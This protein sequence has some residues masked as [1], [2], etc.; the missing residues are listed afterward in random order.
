MSHSCNPKQL[1]FLEFPNVKRDS[2]FLWFLV[3]LWQYVKS[4]FSWLIA[5]HQILSLFCSDELL[6][7]Q[8]IHDGDDHLNSFHINRFVQFFIIYH[9]IQLSLYLKDLL[10][11]EDYNS[12]SFIR[13]LNHYVLSM[14]QFTQSFDLCL[15][16]VT[17]LLNSF[18]MLF[19]VS[20]IILH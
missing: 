11:S 18:I 19:E 8:G 20:Q 16:N 9:I 10:V 5:A 15:R 2:P 3:Y 12:W 7:F 17:S 6:L 1:A 13:W 14:L 4:P